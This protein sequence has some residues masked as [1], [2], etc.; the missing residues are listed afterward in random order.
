MWR[1]TR[2]T[3]QKELDSPRLTNSTQ[4][5]A[6]VPRELVLEGEGTGYKTG[7][8][9][10]NPWSSTQTSLWFTCHELFWLNYCDHWWPKRKYMGCSISI[11]HYLLFIYRSEVEL[12]MGQTS[13]KWMNREK[14][15]GGKVWA[16]KNVSSEVA[17]HS[18]NLGSSRKCG[19]MLSNHIEVGI[20]GY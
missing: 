11:P 12:T 17:K 15:G 7:R 9:N 8:L 10:P 20:Q 3:T 1:L 19:T 4:A 6:E 13:R 16:C 14:E 2:Q 18:K 5:P